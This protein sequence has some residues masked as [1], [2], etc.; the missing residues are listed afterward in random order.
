[1]KKFW[2]FN[3]QRFNEGGE[4]GSGGQDGDGTGAGNGGNGGAGSNVGGDN[5]TNKQPAVSFQTQEDYDKALQGAVTDYLKSLG[6]EKAEDLKGIIDAHKQQEEA[7]KT[8]ETKLAERDAELKT[9]NSTIQSL[10]VENAFILEAI[11]Q[12][13]DPEKLSDA[14]R[15]ADLSKVEVTDGGKIKNIDKHVSELVAAK[16]WLKV[17]STPTGHTPEQ[18]PPGNTK[19]SIPNISDLRKM[20]RI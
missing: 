2:M 17:E 13:I 10:R 20:Q 15:L 1:M 18:K 19:T 6:I 8:A 9:A 4:G 7:N 14:I 12:G 5:G 11:K 3:I 16:P